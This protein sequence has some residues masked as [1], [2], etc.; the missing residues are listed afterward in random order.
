MR[1]S[2]LILS[3]LATALSLGSLEEARAQRSP[4][5]YL[6]YPVG[7]DRQLA[8]W[9]EVTGY[10]AELASLS[11]R[12]RIDTLGSTTLGRPF[13]LLTISD[14]MNLASLDER[15]VRD[16]LLDHVPDPESLATRLYEAMRLP[17]LELAIA[18]GRREG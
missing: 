12:V 4:S 6:G 11:E 8:D 17:D 10:L 14:P 7:A 13:V 1:S 3:A 9:T 16:S 5:D 15:F 18:S 2:R